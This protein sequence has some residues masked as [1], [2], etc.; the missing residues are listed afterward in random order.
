MAIGYRALGIGNVA[1][2]GAGPGVGLV[3]EIGVVEAVAAGAGGE[4]DDAVGAGVLAAVESVVHREGAGDQ[5]VAH[6]QAGGGAISGGGEA[7]GFG[8]L[9]VVLV[10]AEDDA[11]AALLEDGGQDPHVLLGVVLQ[12]DVEG[13]MVIHHE[14]P[15]GVG[16]G[17][18]LGNPALEG[19]VGG[20]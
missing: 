20:I 12:A 14:L 8:A 19:G 15:G 10:A 4:V 7:E 9:V 1:V 6:A 3:R 11:D 5:A 17:Q 2:L 13:W 18:V 16:A